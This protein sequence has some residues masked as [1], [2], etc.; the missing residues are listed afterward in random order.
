MQVSRHATA[1]R[2]DVVAHCNSERLTPFF[3]RR[4]DAKS[5]VIDKKAA[6]SVCVV[7][8][9][10]RQSKDRCRVVFAVS[11]RGEDKGNA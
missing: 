7:F 10:R 6:I 3:S 8:A 2:V 5:D 9:F 1:E 4:R 11:L